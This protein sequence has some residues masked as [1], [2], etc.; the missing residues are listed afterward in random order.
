MTSTALCVVVPTY[1]Q[2]S[3]P[4]H[5]HRASAGAAAS[6]SFLKHCFPSTISSRYFHTREYS[7][8]ILCLQELICT[9]Q[10]SLFPGLNRP[11]N[12]LA[13]WPVGLLVLTLV[14]CFSLLQVSVCMCLLLEDM[15]GMWGPACLCSL[16]HVLQARKTW[17]WILTILI[18]SCVTQRELLNFS[19]KWFFHLWSGAKNLSSGV[20]I[21][22]ESPCND[23]QTVPGS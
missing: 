23:A 4:L 3:F 14:C 1:F 17:V 15:I 21:T 7:L 22:K 6:S 9:S 16:M 2:L 12:R 11:L 8:L 19:E 20:V 10:I 5:D 18:S 13:F